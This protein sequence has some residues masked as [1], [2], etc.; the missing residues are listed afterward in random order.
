MIIEE[1]FGNHLKKIRESK[2]ISQE[3]LSKRSGLSRTYISLV[4]NGKKNPTLTTIFRLSKALGI[5]P[6]VL[7]DGIEESEN[8]H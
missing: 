1:K 2:S 5:K 7:I 6:S 8:D 3:S 4:E